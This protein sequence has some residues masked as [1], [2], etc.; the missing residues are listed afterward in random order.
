MNLLHVDSS[1]VRDNSVSRMVSAAVVARMQAIHGDAL[2]V[3]RRDVEQDPLPHLSGAH[4][5]DLAK[6]GEVLDEFL[7]ADIVVVGCPMY[8]FSVPSQ[9]KSWIDR[10]AVAGRTFRYSENGPVGL[11]TGKRVVLAMSRGSKYGPD[12]RTAAAEHAESYLKAV[13]AFAGSPVAQSIVA[14]GIGL[15]PEQRRKALDAALAEVSRLS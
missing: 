11:A 6:G 1:I 13:F 7:A 3:S 5:G 4:L 14:E 9:L 10:I 15:G 12:T 2:H 8:N